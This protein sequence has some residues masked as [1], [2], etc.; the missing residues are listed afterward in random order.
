MLPY[1]TLS[2]LVRLLKCL[3]PLI[4]H[5]SSVNQS[6]G[7]RTPGRVWPCLRPPLSKR[8]T[9]P[10]NPKTLMLNYASPLREWLSKKPCNVGVRGPFG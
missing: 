4:F 5:I 2:T 3:F 8:K 10:V 7:R 1:H 9:S 6:F